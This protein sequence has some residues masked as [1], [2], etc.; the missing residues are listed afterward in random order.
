MILI[1]AGTNRKNSKTLQ[2]AKFYFRVLQERGL[3]ADL[4]SLADLPHDFVFSAL[5]EN[6]GKNEAFNEF[7]QK[8]KAA[9]KYVIICPE[10]NGSFPGVLKAFLDGLDFPS[11]MKNK[12]VL[13]AS[14]SSGTMGGALALSHLTDILH[15]LGALVLPV[16]LRIPEFHKNFNSD[17]GILNPSLQ[18]VFEEQIASL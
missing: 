4:I 12:P 18:K 10:Y 3:G 15:Y 8:V 13:L 17:E 5:Y 16:K 11:F 9:S 2:T 7:S 1:I 14:I 6:Q